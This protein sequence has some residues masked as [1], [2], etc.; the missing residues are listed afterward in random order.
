MFR[1]NI[2]FV[3]TL[4]PFRI[5]FIKKFF[6]S[7]SCSGPVYCCILLNFITLFLPFLVVFG[8][9]RSDISACLRTDSIIHNP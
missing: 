8:P 5:F 4:L 2:I 9:V 7:F 6:S 1:I 3:V